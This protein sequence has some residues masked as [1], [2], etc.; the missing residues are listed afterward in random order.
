MM[1]RWPHIIGGV[2][3]LGLGVYGVYDEY[4]TVIEFIKGAV[5]PVLA[6]V[7]VVALLAGILSVKVKASH[8][9][10]GLVLLG[11]GI[12]GFFDEYYATLDFFKGS[13]PIALLIA[14]A[15]SVVS[16]V[17]LLGGQRNAQGNCE[18]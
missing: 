15:L 5:Q 14:G 1:S 10:L 6:F 16:G 8:V 2:L 3:A 11:V 7:G 18:E 12:Y 17:K 13:V 4:F 9:V